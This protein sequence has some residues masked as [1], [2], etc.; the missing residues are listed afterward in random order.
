[1]VDVLGG[2]GVALVLYVGTSQVLSGKLTLGL[3]LVFLNYVGSLYRPMRQ[4]SKLSVVSSRG[5][6]GAERVAEVLDADID[7]AD[8]VGAKPAV[9]FAGR[10]EL[11]KVELAYDARPVLHDVSL[12][13]EPGQV[14]ALVGPTGAG[15]SSLISLIPRFYDPRRGSVRIDGIDVR[16]MQ[17]ASL[18]SQIAIV[19][20]EPVL[21]EGTVFENIAY[22]R[23]EASRA[24]V[25]AAAESA[26]VDEFVSRL[27][28]GYETWVGERGATLSG[29]ERQRISIARALI[30]DAPIL[31][32][33]EP[34]S[35]LD[36]QSEWLLLQAI[37]R[38]ISGRTAF[39][40]AHR[41]TTVSGADQV[42]VLSDGRMV[43]HGTHEE[44]IRNPAGIY[45]TFL[46]L[47]VGR[48]AAWRAEVEPSSARGSGR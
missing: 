35:G 17:L 44:L 3:L 15:K 34:T 7:V 18:R 40:I 33:D 32:L 9:P 10:V 30:R 14:V 5:V 11:L 37:Q 24:E 42:V 4:L 26:L 43:E 6:A 29:G 22:G 36:P 41:M 2:V 20:Q 25:L 21:F 45:K 47:Q 39:V 1:V 8:P 38:L 16:S 27:P 28:D 23:P 19:L 46:D 12:V 48:Q 13:V 31:L